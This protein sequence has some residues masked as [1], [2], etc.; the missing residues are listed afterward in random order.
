MVKPLLS[1]TTLNK[2]RIF[3]S[4]RSEWEAALLE[5]I[6]ADQIPAFYGGTMT[7]PD[8]NPMCL[9]KVFY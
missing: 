7:D 1:Q 9:T 2:I 8:G 6:D 3:G 5:E 4:N